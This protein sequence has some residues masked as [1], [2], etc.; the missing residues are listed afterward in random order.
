MAWFFSIKNF[1]NINHFSLM[2]ILP[3]LKINLYNKFQH[4]KSINF[5]FTFISLTIT[6]FVSLILLL[7]I[8]SR[9]INICHISKYFE[10]FPSVEFGLIY[11]N[12]VSTR[13]PV[14]E[15]WEKKFVSSIQ[16]KSS[17]GTSPN[18][19]FEHLITYQLQQEKFIIHTLNKDLLLLLFVF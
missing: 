7:Y 5:D 16:L 13:S 6:V 11:Q 8:F 15:E 1:S 17:N 2:V 18:K 9:W 14:F 12:R 10:K 3:K 4:E 19:I